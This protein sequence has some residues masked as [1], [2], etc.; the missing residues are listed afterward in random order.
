MTHRKYNPNNL[1]WPYPSWFGDKYGPNLEHM[2]DDYLRK[3]CLHN[4][5][6]YKSK[7]SR[8]RERHCS[9]CNADYFQLIE[10]PKKA[11]P[12][13]EAPNGYNKKEMSWFMK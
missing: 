8:L 2:K 1:Y 4:I 11:C 10:E 7:Y 3:Q 12:F 9:N 13:C 6:Y 5:Q